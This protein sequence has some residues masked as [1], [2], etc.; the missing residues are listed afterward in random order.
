[1]LCFNEIL[2]KAL[3]NSYD[4]RIGRLEMDITKERL[5][6]TKSI[7]YPALSLNFTNEY[8]QDL[9]INSNNT[10][11]VGDS[12]ITGN[13]SGFQH[14]VV[15]SSQYLL[16]DFGKRGFKYQN[17]Q[18]DVTLAQKNIEQKRI[19]LKIEILSL[20]GTGLRLQKK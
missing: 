16:Y 10:V 13:D 1:M 14:S 4:L 7:Y 12:I 15:L 6:E 8:N 11:S 2:Q 17:A 3:A 19:D 9:D 20:Y 18:R 5:I